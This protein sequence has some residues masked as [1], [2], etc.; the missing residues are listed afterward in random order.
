MDLLERLLGPDNAR[1]CEH[2]CHRKQKSVLG[3]G[4]FTVNSLV[5]PEEPTSSPLILGMHR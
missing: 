2:V 4:C 1:S 5:L 3:S